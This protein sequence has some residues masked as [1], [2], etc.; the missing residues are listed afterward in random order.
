MLNVMWLVLTNQ[1]ALLQTSI[2]KSA[3]MKFIYD[4]CSKFKQQQCF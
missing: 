1:S 3:S 4:I 2:G